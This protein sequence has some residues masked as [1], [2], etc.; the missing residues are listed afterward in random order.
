MLKHPENKNIY[1]WGIMFLLVLTWGS[2]FILMKRG[3]ESYSALQLGTLRIA[4]SFLFLLPFAIYRLHR[5]KR[6]HIIYFTLV[7]FIG[8]G[9]PAVMFAKAQT[10]LDSQLA[11]ILNSVSPLFTLIVGAMFFGFKTKWFNVMGVFIG[12][13]GAVGLLWAAN[14]KEFSLNFEYGMYIIVATLFYAI[15]I[16]IVKKYLKDVDAITIAAFAFVTIGI[17]AVIVLF[18]TDFSTRLVSG[19]PALIN[20]GYIAI[21]AIVGTALALMIYNYLIK[22]AS[23][24]FAASVTYLIPIVAVMWGFLDGEPFKTSYIIWILFIFVGVYLVN[25]KAG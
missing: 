24:L 5:V 20:L 7:G 15:N 3:L 6:R 2:S 8:S 17:P 13:A 11:G 9:F 12:L 10:V 22:I 18:T 1:K 23:I 19:T 14:E 4:I 16:N 21:L 25:H